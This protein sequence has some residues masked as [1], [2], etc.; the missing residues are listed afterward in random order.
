MNLTTAQSSRL[1]ALQSVAQTSLNVQSR[2]NY[3]EYRARVIARKADY[4]ATNNAIKA[5]A[6]EN[7][8]DNVDGGFGTLLFES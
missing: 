2:P 7:W 1:L 6:A 4:K 8:Y 5:T 3:D